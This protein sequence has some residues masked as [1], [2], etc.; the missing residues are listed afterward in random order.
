MDLEQWIQEQYLILGVDEK[1]QFIGLKPFK[2]RLIAQCP[3]INSEKASI[4][5]VRQLVNR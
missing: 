3:I 4:T 2:H 1:G 5:Q